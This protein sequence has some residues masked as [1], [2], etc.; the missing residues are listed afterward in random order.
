MDMI[1]FV[2]AFDTEVRIVG[3]RVATGMLLADVD[4]RKTTILLHLRL[5]RRP[6]VDHTV[7]L[8]IAISRP[9]C[10]W[11]EGCSSAE[12]LGSGRAR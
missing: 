8:V 6:Q 5:D 3:N 2:L 7:L 9:T 1:H 10:N 12:T 11:K 4:P